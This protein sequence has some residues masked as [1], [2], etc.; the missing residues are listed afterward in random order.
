[1]TLDSYLLF[2]TGSVLLV[3]IPGPDMVYLLARSVAQGRRAGLIAA[4]GFNVG[5][6][7]HLAAALLGLSAMLAASPRA[8]AAVRWLGAAYLIYLG[9]QALLSRESP[10]SLQSGDSGPRRLRLVFWQAFLSDVL[11]PKVGLFFLAFLPQFISRDGTQRTMQLLLLGITVNVIA[12]A[13]NVPLVF[14]STRVSEA[15]RRSST[16]AHRL[17][18]MMGVVFIVLGLRVALS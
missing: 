8:F 18:R 5:A 9:A 10:L 3:V 7:C 1:M 16:T 17:T 13:I 14:V 15:L 4:L 6:Y 12:L 11:N 2:V